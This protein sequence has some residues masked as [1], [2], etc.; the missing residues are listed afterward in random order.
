MIVGCVR[1]NTLNGIT[2]YDIKCRQH[3]T[4][5]LQRWI[6]QLNLKET[7]M[8]FDDELFPDLGA[9]NRSN[10]MFG[11]IDVSVRLV[12][13]TPI[14]HGVQVVRGYRYMFNENVLDVMAESASSIS[15]LREIHNPQNIDMN[16]SIL[17]DAHGVTLDT[18]TLD[19]MY[20]FVLV[21]SDA[22]PMRSRFIQGP[23]QRIVLTGYFVDIPLTKSPLGGDL[24]LNEQAVMVFT[25]A[26]SMVLNTGYNA[27]GSVPARVQNGLDYVPGMAAMLA[28]GS[29]DL[30]F[31][32]YT[33]LS[34]AG[35]FSYEDEFSVGRD[36]SE[37]MLTGNTNTV[38]GSKVAK[39]VDGFMKSPKH[40]LGGIMEAINIGYADAEANMSLHGASMDTNYGKSTTSEFLLGVQRY[41]ANG[42]IPRMQKAINP[43]DPMTLNA[44][45]DLFP[46]A[47][48]IPVEVP[49]SPVD[50][51]IDQTHSTK[52]TIYSSLIGNVVSGICNDLG[53]ASI[54]F[55]Y[56]SYKGDLSR[57]GAWYIE[58][59]S[60]SLITSEDADGSLTKA[61][62]VK[63]RKLIELNLVPILRL[64]GG[65]FMVQVKF[66]LVTATIIDLNFLDEGRPEEGWFITP[67]RMGGLSNPT[68]GSAD[69]SAVNEQQL[70]DLY[71]ELA[72]NGTLP[73]MK[74]YDNELFR[75]I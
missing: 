16:A 34:M 42:A 63:F 26:E 12:V 74:E 35:D 73:S 43:A 75:E 45:K 29:D 13:F 23:K 68:L 18:S 31:C 41:M 11:D 4:H 70:S 57:R 1:T 60:V 66:D 3:C 53:I 51:C 61:A 58:P 39:A 19:D 37:F 5:I 64:I 14:S 65:E 71:R 27:H 7:I 32:D 25:H 55:R 69:L 67:N 47:E 8:N 48:I 24:V 28:E 56:D 6:V 49:R 10:S 2:F 54:A 62:V 21:I 72:L 52:R 38:G 59:T 33:S 22:H 15:A 20:S 9:E 46:S 17:P 36:N 50:N 30:M 44:F 40:Q